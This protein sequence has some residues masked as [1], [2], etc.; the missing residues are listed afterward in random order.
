M[1]HFALT[2]PQL[3]GDLV[4]AGVDDAG[5]ER[6]ARVYEFAER[7]ADGLYRPQGQPFLCHLVRVASIT[8]A[9][10]PP[11]PVALAAMV[12][13]SYELHQFRDSRR[14]P[15]DRRRRAQVAAAVGADVEELVHGYHDV[16]WA[17]RASYHLTRPDD[18]RGSERFVVMMRLAN[19]LEDLLDAAPRCCT[20][21]MVDVAARAAIARRIGCDQLAADLEEAAAACLAAAPIPAAA[22]RPADL[23]YERAPHDRWAAH[24]PGHRLARLPRAAARR[25]KRALKPP[26]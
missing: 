25:V 12:H 10:Q 1:R 6:A 14:R 17:S 8:F 18:P 19:D 20:A 15:P 11:F 2:Y 9:Q 22:V 16:P 4:D 3:V 24:R 21:L 5:I 23:T 13:S 7:M 26:S